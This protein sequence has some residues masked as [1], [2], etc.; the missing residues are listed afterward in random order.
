MAQPR[1]RSVLITGC[2][3]GIGLGLVRGLAA[4]SAS[5]DFVFATCRYPEKA[6]VTGRGRRGSPGGETARP[7]G[8]PRVHRENR[9]SCAPRVPGPPGT[10]RAGLPELSEE[11][12]GWSCSPERSSWPGGLAGSG[13]KRHLWK[14]RTRRAP[15][16]TRAGVPAA[17]VQGGMGAGAEPTRGGRIGQ[18]RCWEGL[19]GWR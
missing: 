5:P 4:A 7:A 18:S 19:R 9:A 17:G 13:R 2:S 3:R 8:K 1:C 15:P 12:L 10:G 14:R 6:Q 11:Q 16:C